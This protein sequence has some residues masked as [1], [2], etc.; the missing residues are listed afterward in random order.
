MPG[1][2]CH[3]LVCQ[4]LV[5]RVS[6]PSHIRSVSRPVSVRSSPLYPPHLLPTPASPFVCSFF[7][8]EEE[9]TL[10]YFVSGLDRNER[11]KLVRRRL[12]SLV[13]GFCLHPRRL[14]APL[15]AEHEA[16]PHRSS[17]P[18]FVLRI[19]V[20][21]LRVLH[22]CVCACVVSLFQCVATAAVVVVCKCVSLCV[23][24]DEWASA[25]V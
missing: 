7:I 20:G 17:P 21:R 11:A 5:V 2:I 22:V 6:F 13:V 9:C 10:N 16:R 4:A 12:V 1:P 15:S 8:F 19:I 3:C 14:I 25:D 23:V 18:Y 24:V